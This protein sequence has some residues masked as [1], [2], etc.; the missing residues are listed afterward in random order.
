MP[1]HVPPISRRDFL[2]GTIATGAGLLLPRRVWAD[3]PGADPN[4]WV[5]LADTHVWEHLDR[6]KRGIKPAVNFEAARA[7]FVPLDPKPAGALVAGDLAFNE[8]NPGDYAML[9]D[10]IGPIREAGIPL[11][12]ALG[13]H[14]HRE[15]FYAAFP[16]AKPDGDPPVA[17]KHVSIVETPHAD[18]ILLDSLQRTNHTPGRI[19]EEQLAWLARTLDARPD[20][21]ALV[22]AHHNPD[23]AEKTSALEDTKALFEVLEPRKQV[24]AFLF[25]HSHKWILARREGLHLVNL[26][27]L[28][29]VFDKSQP[30]GWVDAHL[31]PGGTTLVLHALDPAHKANGQ[32]VR[33]QWRA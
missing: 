3:G 16:D 15:H 19:G 18:W 4:R 24:K 21:P 14:D 5:L 20:R 31:E 11:H 17:D 12:F 23:W 10:L 27:T 33:L 26:P 22:M 25:G 2:A 32:T 29:W 28:V 9:A 8:G 7:G 1:I 30:Q 6:E 13:N